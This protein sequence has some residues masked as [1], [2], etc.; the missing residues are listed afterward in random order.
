M[1]ERREWPGISGNKGGGPTQRASTRYRLPDKKRGGNARGGTEYGPLTPQ[2]AVSC[3]ARSRYRRRPLPTR[4]VGMLHCLRSP[5][6]SDRGRLVGVQHD[7]NGWV[8]CAGGHR[9]WGRYGAAGLLLIDRRSAGESLVL[10]QHRA[11]WTA[12]GNTWGV[13]GGARDSHESAVEAALREALEE[14]GISASAVRVCDQ[15]VDDH[16]GGWSYTTVRADLLADVE[17]VAEAESAEL[18]WVAVSRVD[19]LPLHPGF[20]ASW[21]DLRDRLD[22]ER[23]V[24]RRS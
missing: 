5:G 21:P 9:H 19:A 18:R 23:R 13:P 7:G 16:G 22:Q 11:D 10:L 4:I 2:P 1:R 3:T 20:A 15:V 24:D 14:T 8:T 17:L 6:R 12:H